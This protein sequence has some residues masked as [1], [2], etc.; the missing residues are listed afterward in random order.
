VTF[1]NSIFPSASLPKIPRKCDDFIL[2][3]HFWCLICHHSSKRSSE[4]SLSTYQSMFW[5]CD[6][7]GMVLRNQST[8]TWELIGIP[9]SCLLPR[10]IEQEASDMDPAT[11]IATSPPGWSSAA[12]GVHH[13]RCPGYPQAHWVRIAGHETIDES[14]TP[15]GLPKCSLDGNPCLKLIT[16]S[17]WSSK[18]SRP[19]SS[20]CP[21]KDDQRWESFL[22]ISGWFF[23]TVCP[24]D[25]LGALIKGS[26]LG[27]SPRQS[28]LIGPS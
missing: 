2:N 9:S 13:R 8:I 27:P 21:H 5:C 24:S 16:I 7:H 18:Y 10:P 11:C 1:P 12:Y 3:S 17:H 23:H 4:K 15:L 26:C 28:D 19:E 22:R 20:P 25:A 14:L 6:F